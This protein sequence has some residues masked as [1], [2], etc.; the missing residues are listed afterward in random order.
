MTDTALGALRRRRHAVRLV[1]PGVEAGGRP[2][3]APR[4][5]S[6]VDWLVESAPEASVEA[7]VPG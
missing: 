1:L 6:C 5:P 7:V 4:N 2:P 3:R